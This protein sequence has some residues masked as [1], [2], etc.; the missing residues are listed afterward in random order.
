MSTTAKINPQ[1]L[2]NSFL[3]KDADDAVLDDVAKHCQAMELHAGDH[4]FE[5]D[6]PSDAMFV[7]ESGQIHVVRHYADGSEVIIATESPYYVIG[8]LSLLAN[9]PRTGS[10]V[11]VGDCDL[12]MLSRE[13]ILDICETMPEIA[14][15]ALTHL[16][17]RLYQLNLRVRESAIGNISAR[18]ASVLIL[19]A[20]NQTGLIQVSVP[21]TRVARATA[22]DVDIVEKLFREW[23]DKG[24]IGVNKQQITIRDLE[25][26]RNLAG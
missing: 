17:N 5:Q 16:G 11:A 25:S 15:R 12:L 3:F 14:V 23:S 10:V 24:I 8:E 18:V 19:L 2:R 6:A 26:I 1:L 4:L 20:D 21:I 7:L 13:A 9:K 22:I